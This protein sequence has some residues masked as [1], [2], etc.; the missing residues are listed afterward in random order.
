MTRSEGLQ[1]YLC[2][3]LKKSVCCGYY[4]KFNEAFTLFCCTE[5][6]WIVYRFYCHLSYR[7]KYQYSCF[8]RSVNFRMNLYCQHFSQNTNKKLSEFLPSLHRAEILTIFCSW[9]GRNYDF[10]N[11]FWKYLNFRARTKLSSSKC[12]WT[13]IWAI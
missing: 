10:I 12:D 3:I 9:F 13:R 2:I 4:M 8:W 7:F 11:S 5:V 6:R 1:Q